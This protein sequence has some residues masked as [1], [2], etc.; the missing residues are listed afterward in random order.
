MASQLIAASK[1][2]TFLIEKLSG[3]LQTIENNVIT[4]VTDGEGRAQL[5]R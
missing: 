3:D 4:A 1:A 2:V 5:G